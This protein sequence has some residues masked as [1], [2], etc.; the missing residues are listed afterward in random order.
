MRLAVSAF[1]LLAVSLL[2]ASCQ[3][4][5]KDECIA[6]DWRV[7]GEQDGSEGRDPQKRFGNHAKSCE[8]ANVVPDQT[9]WNEGYQRGLLKFCTPLRGLSHGQSGSAYH[10]VCPPQLEA[11]FLSGYRLGLEES[12]TK[13][14]IR[15]LEGRIRSAE[16]SIDDL[17][18]KISKGKV[19]Q[20]DARR[21]IRR[22]RQD[23]R[24][25]NREIG[26]AE[27]YLGEIQ[28]RIEYFTSDPANTAVPYAG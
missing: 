14:N 16:Y 6:A 23:I 25:W 27:A 3:T 22:H 18:E 26:R 10:N 21:E 8:R 13:G 2:L 1:L 11:G 15:N 12:S 19:D 28:R 9:A 5:S 20:D 4:L 17:E 24:D 7:I